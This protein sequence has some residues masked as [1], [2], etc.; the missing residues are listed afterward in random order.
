MIRRWRLLM[1]ATDGSVR[2]ALS[3]NGVSQVDSSTV[4]LVTDKTICSKA[5]RAYNGV[6][7]PN[8]QPPSGSVYVIKVGTNYIVR[9]PVQRGGEWA[10]DVVIDNRFRVK[11]QLLSSQSPTIPSNTAP[12]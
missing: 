11:C 9:D 7:G 1:V 2:L 10:G 6:L 4:V 8:A 3:R 12:V 5:V